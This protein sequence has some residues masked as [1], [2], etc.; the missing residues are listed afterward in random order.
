MI[1]ANFHDDDFNEDINESE[2]SEEIWH[3][4]RHGFTSDN[5]FHFHAYREFENFNDFRDF[6]LGTYRRIVFGFFDYHALAGV[7]SDE[8]ELVLDSG[9]EDY[10]IIQD[11]T[12]IPSH[13]FKMS[14]SRFST[15]NFV[16]DLEGECNNGASECEGWSMW[17]YYMIE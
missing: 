7:A 6:K 11:L 13:V 8:L 16:A 12:P 1:C 4:I 10:E 3:M 5:V 9:F 15:Y 2:Y 17:G 14:E